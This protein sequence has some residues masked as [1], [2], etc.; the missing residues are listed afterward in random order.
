MDSGTTPTRRDRLSRTTSLPMLTI[1]NRLT[2]VN[3][4]VRLPRLSRIT[5]RTIIGKKDRANRQTVITTK[6]RLIIVRPA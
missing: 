5:F 4:T 6:A 1:L 3:R 2:M